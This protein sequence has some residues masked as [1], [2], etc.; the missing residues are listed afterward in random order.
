MILEF[1]DGSQLEVST[2]IGG[3]KLINGVLRDTLQIEVD[4]STI[5]FNELKNKFKDNQNTSK[6]YTYVEDEDG[7]ITDEKVE[8]GEDYSIFVS[9]SDEEKKIV[10]PLEK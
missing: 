1:V 3:P 4:P 2:I 6:L 5:E 10:S 7:N 9:I 8:I